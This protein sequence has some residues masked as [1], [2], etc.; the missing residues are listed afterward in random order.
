MFYNT[1]NKNCL[2]FIMQI[3]IIILV[4]E[5]IHTSMLMQLNI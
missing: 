4:P 2:D 1:K 3:K 5:I